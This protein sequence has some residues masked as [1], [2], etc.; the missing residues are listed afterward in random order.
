M[1]NTDNDHS[2]DDH[3]EETK[4]EMFVEIEIVRYYLENFHL[5]SDHWDDNEQWLDFSFYYSV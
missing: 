5:I 4:L 1:T 3:R 2:D